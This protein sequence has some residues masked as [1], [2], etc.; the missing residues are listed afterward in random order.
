MAGGFASAV[1]SIT[2]NVLAGVIAFA[3]LG[4]AYTGQGIIAGM[5]SSIVAGF[6]AALFGGAPGMICGP[7]ATTSM[8]F[9][10]L[11]ISL[12]ATGRFD[13]PEGTQV[14]LS[15]AFGA[16]LISGSV[17]I[18]L[19]AFRVGTLVQFMPYP[20]VS[21]IRNTTAILLIYSQSWTFF[22]VTRQNWGAFIQDL[23]Q[24]QPATTLVAASTAL[25]AWK[26]GR[27]MPKPVVP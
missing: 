9:A 20:V 5:L 6:M 3:P 23:G 19:G 22:G 26:G 4:P 25:V 2:G 15:L 13:S 1:V 8:A 18:L 16:V 14:L 21:G 7:K 17:Q 27:W 12:M 10:A 24:I 11:L